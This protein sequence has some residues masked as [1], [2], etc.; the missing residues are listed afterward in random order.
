[1]MDGGCC[2][3]V[4]LGAVLLYTPR[5]LPCRAHGRV[6]GP[7]SLSHPTP[8]PHRSHA[9]ARALRP[10]LGGRAGRGL[11]GGHAHPS[12]ADVAPAGR[13]RRRRRPPLW[14]SRFRCGGGAASLA[15]G[16]AGLQSCPLPPPPPQRP[17]GKG[18]KEQWGGGQA[19]GPVLHRYVRIAGTRRRDGD[20]G[21]K[22]TLWM[23]PATRNGEWR[24][25]SDS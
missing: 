3:E 25:E 15:R 14:P 8:A 22:G 13:N 19:R 16:R 23:R 11:W 5:L 1:M 9:P 21:N 6:V 4:L 7:P 20:G 10:T 18:Q 2:G 24:V 12:V 17:R